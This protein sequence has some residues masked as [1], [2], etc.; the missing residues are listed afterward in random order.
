MPC[1]SASASCSDCLLSGGS[2]CGWC[3]STLSCQAGNK[4]GPSTPSDCDTWAWYFNYCPGD[5]ADKCPK[6]LNCN[7]CI[8]DGRSDPFTDGTSCGWCTEATGSQRCANGQISGPA[9]GARCV[10]GGWLFSQLSTPDECPAAPS[11]TTRTPT[12]TNQFVSFSPTPTLSA[13][14]TPA[15]TGNSSGGSGNASSNFF[16]PI[17]AAAASFVLIFLCFAGIA[18]GYF[19]RSSRAY[20]KQPA[21][22]KLNPLQ[23]KE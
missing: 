4:F 10:A 23:I 20:E 1:S 11:S 15:F 22:I 12:T 7:D 6:L 14:V 17:N 21:T 5:P 2:S 3:E 16:S 8:L 9:V 19:L 18:V 13:T